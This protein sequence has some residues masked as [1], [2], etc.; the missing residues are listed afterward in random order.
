[1]VKV[2]PAKDKN[3]PENEKQNKQKKMK[4]IEKWLEEKTIGDEFDDAELGAMLREDELRKSKGCCY[5]CC[6]VIERSIF[7]IWYGL[8]FFDFEFHKLERVRDKPVTYRTKF[9]NRHFIIWNIVFVLAAIYVGSNAMKTVGTVS[10]EKVD[11]A[12]L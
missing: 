5:N 9:I 8:G 2:G 7:N 11:A 4:E 10:L 3:E 1:M 12:N 6:R